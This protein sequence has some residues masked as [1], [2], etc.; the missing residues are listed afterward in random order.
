MGNFDVGFYYALFLRR[1]PYFL[2]VA[3]VVG[4]VGTAVVY[5][6]PTV[7]M[8]TARILVESPQ[9]PTSMA[10]STVPTG[11]MEQFQI[12]E[13]DVMSRDS[14]LGLAR[15]FALYRN[16]PTLSDVEIVDDMR[17]RIGVNPLALDVGS[18]DPGAI[19]FDVTFQANDAVLSA[20]VTNELVSM[21]LKRDVDLRTSRA[22]DTLN[23][24]TQEVTRLNGELSKLDG[25]ILAFKTEHSDALPDSLDFRRTQQLNQE[26]HALTLAQ[27]EATLRRRRADLVADGQLEGGPPSPQEQT[28][29]TLRQALATQLTVFREDSPTI[30]ALKGRMA[31]LEEAPATDN[32]AGMAGLSRQ[33][34]KQLADIDDRLA[35]IAAEQDSIR[36]SNAELSRT[37]AETPANESALN[38]LLRNHNNIQ[39][40]YDAAVAQLADASTGDQIE[41]RFKGARL[42]LKESALP[43]QKPYKPNRLLLLV[44]TLFAALGLGLGA[45]AAPEF[46]NRKIRRPAELVDKLGIHPL[47]TIPYIGRGNEWSRRRLASTLAAA[48]VVGA[49]PLIAL[50]INAHVVPLDAVFG[51]AIG[52]LGGGGPR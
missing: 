50:A 20:Q 10:R 23:F 12:I 5:L 48:V 52:K 38:A 22:S 18:G 24:F 2:A 45:I 29:E 16:R 41:A 30:Q 46:F 31:A 8:A 37:I 1:L 35:Q 49:I 7:Y 6:I 15:R 17:A 4:C 11:P 44:G 3:V 28:L 27:E 36:K 47:I 39:A 42:S 19:A 21:I 14:L 25:E 34:E 13:Q 43:P 9:I 33:I 26:Q 32:S 51:G 40:Q